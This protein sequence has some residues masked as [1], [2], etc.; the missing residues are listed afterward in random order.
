MAGSV[1]VSELPEAN[2]PLVVGVGILAAVVFYALYIINQAASGPETAI[3]GVSGLVGSITGFFSNIFSG[4]T[5]WF[6]DNVS[7]PSDQ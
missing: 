3:N 4:L 7:S 6:N 5:G 2:W 1:N